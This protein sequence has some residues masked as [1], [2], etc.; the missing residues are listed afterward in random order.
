MV[1]SAILAAFDRKRREVIV[2]ALF[3][4]FSSA[5][6]QKRWTLLLA[7]IDTGDPYL[8]T[9]LGDSLW[10]GI[11]L[12]GAPHIFI[13]HAEQALAARKRQK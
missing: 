13:R 3:K 12:N 9:Q 1:R 5:S 7:I 6:S 4:E 10:I 8:L 11:C 2:L